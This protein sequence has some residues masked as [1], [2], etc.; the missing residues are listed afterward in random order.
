MNRATPAQSSKITEAFADFL[1]I[2]TSFYSFS[3]AYKKQSK[4]RAMTRKLELVGTQ[5]SLP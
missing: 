4:R 2:K 5:E 3:C 1:G